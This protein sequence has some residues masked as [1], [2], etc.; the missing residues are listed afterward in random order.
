MKARDFL[1][2]VWPATG[3]FCIAVPHI[4]KEGKRVYKHAVHDNM[5]DAYLDGRAR[6]K[7]TD[8]YFGIFTHINQTMFSQRWNRFTPS[9][10]RENMDAAKCLFLDLDVGKEDTKYASQ[11]D[12]LAALS[13]FLFRTGF[14]APIVVSSGNGLH[15]YWPLKKPVPADDWRPQAALL[16]AILDDNGVSYDPSRTT[17][18]TSVLRM[19][20]TLNHKEPG[21]P[22]P[23]AVLYDGD[24]ETDNDVFFALLTRL[25]GHAK[26]MPI[27]SYATPDGALPTNSGVGTNFPPT[28]PDDVANE[29]EQVRLLRD[30]K[31]QIPEHHWYPVLGVLA[32]CTGGRQV[33]HK[34]SS[35]HPQ[36]THAETERKMD[37][38]TANASVPSCAKLNSDGAQGVCQRCSHFG[39][40]FKNPIVIVNKKPAPVAFVTQAQVQTPAYPQPLCPPP[41]PYN[42]TQGLSITRTD[43][44]GLVVNITHELDLYPIEVT[45]GYVSGH[46][47]NTGVSTWIARQSNA[48]GM[49]PTLK[50]EV[51]GDE[52]VD[53]K[54][55]SKKFVTRGIYGIEVGAEVKKYMS[56]YLRELN[57]NVG[58]KTQYV[59]LGWPAKDDTSKFILNK[60]VIDATGTVE[61]C[62][63]SDKVAIVTDA[64]T[65]GGDIQ[66][67]VDALK[68][69]NRPGYEAHQFFILGSLASALFMA[70]GQ[71][72]VVL[73]AT[74]ETGTGKTSALKA[75]AGFWADPAKYIVNGTANGIT[76]LARDARSMA[77]P[78]LPTMVDEI[79]HM[80]PDD[81]RAMVMAAT[82]ARLRDTLKQDRTPREAH[83]P[84]YRASL[85]MTTANAS[86]HQ[87]VNSG[88]NQ[89]GTANSARVMEVPFTYAMQAHTKGEADAAG[90][91]FDAN[92]GWVGEYFMTKAM[93]TIDSLFH[94]V[95]RMMVRIDAD[96][97][98][99]GSERFMVAAAA[100]IFVAGTFA[101]W[102][103][104]IDWDM[105][106]IYRWFRTV[107]V[108]AMRAQMREQSETVASDNILREFIA[109]HAL[110]TVIV[111]ST[112]G[113]N[114]PT[115]RPFSLRTQ[116]AINHRLNHNEMWI[117]KQVFTDW[118]RRK[119]TTVSSLLDD[120]HRQ[121][122]ITMLDVRRNLSDGTNYTASFN[123]CFVVKA[124]H[125]HII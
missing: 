6:Y 75:A 124:D 123:R 4:N 80:L 113:N 24:G 13:R 87:L 47:V 60:K 9:R 102:H 44:Q 26:P 43:A 84:G 34:W 29:C 35:G 104:L 92:Y 110:D 45:D 73:N 49:M 74:G 71:H 118:C 101:R 122:V 103:G 66:G 31:G 97:G 77:I 14:P 115:A 18:I 100:P 105:D 42:R 5:A 95:R 10:K 57:R 69:F 36:Y 19:P 119:N 7:E 111:D 54:L 85:M 68:F 72:G 27:T 91:A 112:P 114:V 88:N 2:Q 109:A 11:G 59:H 67:Q 23:V 50:F 1:K 20:S 12:A 61:A 83:L 117:S 99:R 46:A 116:I 125:P 3:N 62:I 94:S 120:L 108:P 40:Q 52:L 93:P 96:I 55:L 8:I 90:R 48:K 16:R 63:M 22:K 98:A 30:K 56:A 106:A 82:Q 53:L 32:Y 107:Q 58:L 38:W 25:G 33:A 65:T 41:K 21:N 79:T 78:N 70:T 15:V 17:D 39:G 76:A 89:A 64:M 37:Q 81:A 121:G 86:L 51:S 28:D